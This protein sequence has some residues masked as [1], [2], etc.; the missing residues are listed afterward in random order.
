[1][2]LRQLRYFIAIAEAG[3][4]SAASARLRIAQPALSQHVKA[5]EAEF[6]IPLLQRNPRG[7]VLT[8]AGSSLLTRARIIEAEF[9][10]LRDHVRG[11]AVPSGE[12]RFGMPA[13]IN[14]QLGVALIEAGRR[15]YPG[16][17]IRISEAMSGFVLGWLRE[18]TVDL[19]VLY[20]VHDEK[21]LTLHQALTEDI[22]L[23]A[24][25]DMPDAPAGETVALTEALGRGLILPGQGHGLRELIEAAARNA[26][27]PVAPAIEIDSYRQI[28]QLAARSMGFGMLPATAIREETAAGIF[29]SW[30]I[31]DPRLM[32]R[33]Y[34]G[35]LAG[36]PLSFAS[37]AIA[38]LAWTLLDQLVRTGGW[39]AT[40]NGSDAASPFPSATIP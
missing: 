12:V 21:G 39:T 1:L 32:R 9:L 23:F 20:N 22:R 13:T 28:K 19:A 24:T 37:Q 2:D 33:I 18:G 27:A 16:I 5:M 30:E 7:V 3:S 31:I 8:E 29:R 25:P 34:L 40:W 17:R 14:E 4:F 38:Q 26:G 36:K 11:S 6:G 35:H 10:S 15:L